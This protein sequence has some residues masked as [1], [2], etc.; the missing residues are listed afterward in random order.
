MSIKSCQN[1]AN[2]GARKAS[3][4][5]VDRLS[6]FKAYYCKFYKEIVHDYPTTCIQFQSSEEQEP[7]K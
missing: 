7:T 5:T 6:T 2:V 1:C 4:D 3:F